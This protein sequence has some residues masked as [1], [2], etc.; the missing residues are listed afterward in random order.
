MVQSSGLIGLLIFFLAGCTS[1]AASPLKQESSPLDPRPFGQT[2]DATDT[3]FVN[4][5]SIH[6]IVCGTRTGT[7]ET[8]DRN[9]VMTASHVIG[10]SEVCSI[11]GRPATILSNNSVLDYAILDYPAGA[12]SQKF[13]INCDGFI[14]GEQYLAIGYAHGLDFVVTAGTAMRQ[15]D[16]SAHLR[17]L[18]GR[19]YSGMSGGPVVNM[20]GEQVGITIAKSIGAGPNF[21][22]ARELK[23]TEVCVT[24]EE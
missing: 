8:I 10:E 24:P 6:R 15:F 22:Y 1:P 2:H 16:R 7:A 9:R 18:E 17:L 19:A 13:P 3:Y 5:N 21:I 20:Q 23:E 11:D 12:R 14:A 4:L